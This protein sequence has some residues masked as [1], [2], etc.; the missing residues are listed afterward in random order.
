MLFVVKVIMHLTILVLLSGICYL[1]RAVWG[2]KGSGHDSK[3]YTDALLHG[4]I[5][6]INEYYLGDNAYKLTM[7]C[8]ALC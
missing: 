1:P 2:G 4:S 7:Y 6:L 3:V 8:L 5:R